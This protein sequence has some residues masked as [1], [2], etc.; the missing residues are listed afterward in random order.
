MTDKLFDPV[1]ATEGLS[2]II[3]PSQV[4]EVRVLGV[5]KNNGYGNLSAF[6]IFD[7]VGDAASEISKFVKTHTYSGMYFTPNPLD[8]SVMC[9]RPNML[10]VGSR[11]DGMAKDADVTAIHW[12]LVDFD[13]VRPSGTTAS[14]QQVDDVMS[15][16]RMMYA[17]FC[18]ALHAHPLV[19]FSGNGIHMMWRVD[20]RT[21]ESPLLSRCLFKMQSMLSE[22]TEKSVKI[23]IVNSNPA[24][25]W[26]VPGSYARKGF[27]VEKQGRVFRVGKLLRSPQEISVVPRETLEAFA[28]A[29]ESPKPVKQTSQTSTSTK[30]SI[31][32]LN[33]LVQK[34]VGVRNTANYRDGVKHILN[35]CPFN[36]EH[37][38]PDSMLVQFGDGRIVFYC[39]HN[40]CRGHG[41]FDLR[42]L[43]EPGWRE[44]RR[45]DSSFYAE[46]AMERERALRRA[47]LREEDRLL[48][49]FGQ[50]DY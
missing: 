24:R 7:A 2:K 3:A 35:E 36:A 28:P 10:D 38:A 13:P 48:R 11:D 12:L 25:I 37:K 50:K 41:W 20:L 9:R 31:D 39:S 32:A 49:D 33:W 18:D 44:E 5:K 26:K 30:E 14:D 23:D 42:D 29:A 43:F 45:G 21:D 4:F 16:S 1:L 22:V 17:P 34:G 15:V 47:M 8:E 46:C 27:E 6:G 19:L 40:S